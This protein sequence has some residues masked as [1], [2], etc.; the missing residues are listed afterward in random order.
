MLQTSMPRAGDEASLHVLECALL[1]GNVLTKVFSPISTRATLTQSKRSLWYELCSRSSKIL[2]NNTG[3]R[4]Q[5][6]TREGNPWVP[7]DGDSEVEGRH[8]HPKATM[9]CLGA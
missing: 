9:A 2:V 8:L 4:G 5:S 1:H 3:S 6:G 7:R